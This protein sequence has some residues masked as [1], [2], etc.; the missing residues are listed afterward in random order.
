MF[1]SFKIVFLVLSEIVCEMASLDEF[2]NPLVDTFNGGHAVSFLEQKSKGEPF[3][4][5]LKVLED[6]LYQVGERKFAIFSVNG[7]QGIGKSFLLNYMLKF[8]SQNVTNKESNEESFID[9]SKLE[10]LNTD[11]MIDNAR[12][13]YFRFHKGAHRTTV[14]IQL[15]SKPLIVVQDN[16]EI[17]IIL[18]DCQ[19]DHDNDASTA[20]SQLIFA[21]SAFLSDVMIYNCQEKVTD[22]VDIQFIRLFAESARIL[23]KASYKEKGTEEKNSAFCEEGEPS[24][25][26]SDLSSF[27]IIERPF[28]P[29][30]LVLVRDF[31]PILENEKFKYC[32][33]FYKTEV[34]PEIA[35]EN[36]KINKLDPDREKCASD[37]ACW[38]RRELHEL[39]KSVSCFL[40]PHPGDKI[41]R[42]NTNKMFTGILKLII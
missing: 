36:Y 24:F 19:G 21:F 39:F 8:I 15:W 5:N 34:K 35:L 28:F 9:L 22:S 7:K 31:L 3:T 6:V 30:L 13:N 18:M 11:W 16:E 40:L 17:A 27:E 29:H 33:G 38:K 25:S 4:I 12:P 26:K 2:G 42:D 23:K 37:E 1:F 10:E 41:A 14:G 32:Y 20:D